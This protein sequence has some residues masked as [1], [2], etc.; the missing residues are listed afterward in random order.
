MDDAPWTM[1]AKDLAF[2]IVMA[3]LWFVAVCVRTL[4]TFV[5]RRGRIDIFDY[6]NGSYKRM[7]GW[8]QGH[9]PCIFVRRGTYHVASLKSGSRS[10][11]ERSAG[12][13]LSPREP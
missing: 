9:L 8:G 7:P 11:V 6:T 12:D 13:S 4:V 3:P 10:R 5:Q 1:I 2:D